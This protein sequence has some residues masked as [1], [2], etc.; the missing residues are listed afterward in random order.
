MREGSA[1]STKSA[2]VEPHRKIVLKWL[3]EAAPGSVVRQLTPAI[4]KRLGERERSRLWMQRAPALGDARYM[5]W[6]ERVKTDA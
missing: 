6:L 2:L 5:A 4:L 1:A 3:D